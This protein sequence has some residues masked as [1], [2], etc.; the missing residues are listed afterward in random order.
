MFPALD[1]GTGTNVVGSVGHALERFSARRSDLLD[2]IRVVDCSQTLVVRFKDIRVL[3]VIFAVAVERGL[4]RGLCAV[5]CSGD[6]ALGAAD[7][8]PR[9]SCGHVVI[10]HGEV[11]EAPENT[12]GL[13]I[14]AVIRVVEGV[15]AAVFDGLLGDAGERD[16]AKLVLVVI[17]IEVRNLSGVRSLDPVILNAPRRAGVG[18]G[19]VV[20]RNEIRELGLHARIRQRQAIL[21]ALAR[22]A[23]LEVGG[24]GRVGAEVHAASDGHSRYRL[25]VDLRLARVH[26]VVGKQP[27]HHRAAGGAV[28]AVFDAVLLEPRDHV[29]QSL[30]VILRHSRQIV[31]D[32]QRV[33]LRAAL[34]KSFARGKNCLVPCLFLHAQLVALILRHRVVVRFEL[35]DELNRRAVELRQIFGEFRHLRPEIRKILCVRFRRF[36]LDRLDLRL[37]GQLS[38]VC[39]RRILCLVDAVHTGFVERF[40]LCPVAVREAL[41]RIVRILIRFLELCP[42]IVLDLREVC[43]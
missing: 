7:G 30:L 16:A 26:R 19:V 8:N 41:L 2:R 35:V 23:N 33:L 32:R 1:L 10:R 6:L 28:R 17:D 18:D 36:G 15:E 24:V 5:L 3:L 9:D 13:D 21:V 27:R 11:L 38:G 25:V 34:G 31:L 20:A 42:Q 22:A 4:E 39:G 12:V 40:D 14:R 43:L 29:T 37:G